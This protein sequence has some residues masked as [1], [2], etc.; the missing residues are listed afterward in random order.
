MSLLIFWV[1]L[2]TALLLA[3]LACDAMPEK[4]A[5]AVRLAGD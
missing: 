5:F 2:P 1:A 3:M 4:G